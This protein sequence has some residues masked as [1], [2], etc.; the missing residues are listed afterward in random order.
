MKKRIL[1]VAVVMALVGCTKPLEV[2]IDAKNL[3]FDEA[4]VTFKSFG[5]KA[6]VEGVGTEAMDWPKQCDKLYESFERGD[7]YYGGIA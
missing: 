2:T 5:Y 3:A 4:D 1:S 7:F 6:N